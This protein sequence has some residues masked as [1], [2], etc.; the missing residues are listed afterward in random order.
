MQGVGFRWFVRETARRLGVAGWVAN[1]PDGA[2]ELAAAGA[3]DALARLEGE[4]RHGPPGAQVTDVITLEAPAGDL[5]KPF[6]IQR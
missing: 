6:V 2:V 3:D 4:V 1:R 5:P